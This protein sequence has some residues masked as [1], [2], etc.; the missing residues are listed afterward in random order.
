MEPIDIVLK[1]VFG[2]SAP[3]LRRYFTIVYRDNG[4]AV[5]RHVQDPILYVVVGNRVYII[6]Y[7]IGRVSSRLVYA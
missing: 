6:E 5:V 7:G 2:A 3:R 1:C 4:L